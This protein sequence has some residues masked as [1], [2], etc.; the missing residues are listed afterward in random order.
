MDKLKDFLLHKVTLRVGYI[1][2]AFATAHLVSLLSAPMVQD[3]LGKMGL[4][5]K[6]TDPATLKTWITG[7]VLVAGEFVYRY[8]HTKVILPQVVAQIEAKQGKTDSQPASNNV[9]NAPSDKTVPPAA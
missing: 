5:V 8:F 9:I 1:I 6:V 7:M 4:M 2:A 3:Y